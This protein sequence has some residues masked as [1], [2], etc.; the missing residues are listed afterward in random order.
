MP[1]RV[2]KRLVIALPV[3]VYGMSSDGK[4]FN[5]EAHTLDI[6]RDGAR[7]DGLPQITIGET[8]GVQ[9]GEEK[10]R[11]KVVWASEP[12]A[13]HQCQIG[14]QILQIGPAPWHKTLEATP[15]QSRWVDPEHSRDPFAGA[16]IKSH[17]PDPPGPPS[18]NL[19][20]RVAQ[21][22]DELQ[23][24]EKLIESGAVDSRILQDFREAVNHV[25]QTSWAVQRYLELRDKHQ[26][27]YS[28]VD[29]LV[30]E[31]I[32]CATQLN[33]ELGH[34]VESAEVDH[35]TEGLAQ[36]Q[37][38]VMKLAETLLRILGNPK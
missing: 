14:V 3:R 7:V 25:R 19:S 6:T 30:R 36:L 33:R 24:I 8:V 32:R 20:E 34:D 1:E 35:E 18:D 17:H 2:E 15:E 26:D 9:Y 22:T 4:P 38:V 27:P 28:A 5:Q 10:A 12:D 31:R 29:L 21:A 23:T 11:Y 16:T 37:M 13:N